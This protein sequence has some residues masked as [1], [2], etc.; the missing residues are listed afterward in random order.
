MKK[1]S[2]LVGGAVVAGV[3]LAGG[4]VFAEGTGTGTSSGQFDGGPG[5]LGSIK[6]AIT[7]ML[8]RPM[9]PG[10]AGKVSAVSGTTITVMGRNFLEH[11]EGVENGDEHMM[12]M[13]P[14]GTPSSTMPMPTSTKT[15]PKGGPMTFTVDA[16]GAVV[17]KNGAS[18]TVGAISVGD[19]V[20]VFGLVSGTSVTAQSII[21]G[22]MPRPLPPIGRGEKEGDEHKHSTS[23]A[24]S[25]PNREGK[26]K[27][28]NLIQ[29]NGQP[30]IAGKV[31]AV[32][33]GTITVVTAQGN[34]TY[35]VNAS[36]A[37]V[38][39]GNTTSTIANVA[40]GDN[41]IVQGAVSGNVVTASSIIVQSGPG[42]S[43][44]KPNEDRAGKGPD[45]MGVFRSVGGFF[46]R[47]FGF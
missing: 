34:V 33:S 17:M 13:M 43:P 6:A 3:L 5:G 39:K 44:G 37:T 18:S 26:G 15:N 28:V 25:T 21:V 24:T 22:P 38:V 30:V 4:L 46:Q 10:I 16:S 14:S 20:Y 2:W 19:M 1:N 47:L 8:M 9:Q 29:G 36:S 32:A 40:V 23:T 12:P 45:F 27:P 11:P 35:T 31:T 7:S 41:V 42:N